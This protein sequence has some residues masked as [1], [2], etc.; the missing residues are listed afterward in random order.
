MN[1]DEL[2][3]IQNRIIENNKKININSIFIFIVVSVITYLIGFFI[4]SVFFAI[5]ITIMYNYLTKMYVN[6]DDEKLFKTQFK[7]IFVLSTIKEY[8]D[9]VDFK[10][11]NGFSRAFIDSVG[12]LY[13]ADVYSSTVLL[14]NRRPADFA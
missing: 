4:F 10:P 7:D 1:V 3:E 12:M 14:M 2:K 5:V 13:T 11:D 8:F 6:K 9:D